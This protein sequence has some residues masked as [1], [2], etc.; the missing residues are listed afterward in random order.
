MMWVP[1]SSRVSREPSRSWRS[2]PRS[3]CGEPVT[4][5]LEPPGEPGIVEHETHIVLDRPAVLRARDWPRRRE[6]V[7]GRRRRRAP[8]SSSGGMPSASGRGLTSTPASAVSR[9][10]KVSSSRPAA[11]SSSAAGPELIKRPASRCSVPTSRPAVR[12]ASLIIASFNTC[13]NV[14]E[15]GNDSAGGSP[16]RASR[17]R[18]PDRR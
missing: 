2:S 10:R 13:R 5:L 8:A 4:D 3:A 1:T 6:C 16:D 18:G 11:R 12:A 7:P 14:G 17:R 15:T 9:S